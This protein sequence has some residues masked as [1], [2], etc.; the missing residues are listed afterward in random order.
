M[1]QC[2]YEPTA[3]LAPMGSLKESLC[4]LTGADRG[5]V[6]EAGWPARAPVTRPAPVTAVVSAELAPRGPSLK[7]C[8][9][10][11]TGLEAGLAERKPASS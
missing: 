7:T 10:Q 2:G 4:A 3:V 1:A 5:K 11:A 8:A 6:K 9:P